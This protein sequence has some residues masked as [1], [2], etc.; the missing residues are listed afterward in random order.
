MAWAIRWSLPLACA[1]LK[2]I[3]GEGGKDLFIAE[4]PSSLWLCILGLLPGSRTA[5]VAGNLDTGS[6]GF[7]S[8]PLLQLNVPLQPSSDPSEVSGNVA[9]KFCECRVS[10]KRRGTSFL[11]LPL[12]CRLWCSSR[13]SSSNLGSCSGH[14]MLRADQ[15]EGY[16]PGPGDLTELHQQAWTGLASDF[17]HS[18]EK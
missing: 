13:C 16:G 5:D 10:L 8:Q 2:S 11:A 6:K 18:T 15:E 1:G 4:T 12:S 3:K 17:L 9:C 14:R 7:I